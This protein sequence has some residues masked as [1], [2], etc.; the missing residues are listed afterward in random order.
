MAKS[1]ILLKNGIKF[2]NKCNVVHNEKY[3]YSKS[4]YK[5]TAYKIVVICPIHGDFLQ[6]AA[7]HYSGHG[8]PKC[9]K[10]LYGNGKRSNTKSFIEKAKLIHGDR[11]IYNKVDYKN[12]DINVIIICKEHGDFEQAPRT[13]LSDKGCPKCNLYVGYSRSQWVNYNKNKEGIFYIIKCWNENEKFYKIGITGRSVKERYPY[14]E[15]MPYMYE[16]TKEVKSRDLDYIWNL[17]KEYKRNLK[18]FKYKPLIKFAGG[19]VECFTKI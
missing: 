2:F 12:S 3:D 16:V 1:E 10:L 6:K 8:C 17:E 14:K 11:Y 7:T 5:G 4:E 18:D 15:T 13:H 19:S 9:A